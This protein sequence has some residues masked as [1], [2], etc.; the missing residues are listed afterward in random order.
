MGNLPPKRAENIVDAE[1]KK[2]LIIGLPGIGKTL[3]CE[4]MLRDWASERLFTESQDSE[5][6]IRIAFLIKFRRLNTVGELSLRELLEKA[7]FLPTKHLPDDVWNDIIKNPDKVLILF[8]GADEYKNHSSIA[9]KTVDSGIYSV[10]DRM[11]LHA[12]YSKVAEGKLLDKAAVL[13]TI[14]PTAV[15][16]VKHITFRTYE[17]LGFSPQQVEEYVEKFT[18]DAAGNLSDAGEKIKEHIK[19]NAKISA[20]CYIPA[21]CF[22][23]C[24]SLLHVLKTSAETGKDLTAVG[25]GKLTQIYNVA[26]KVFFFKRSEQHRDKR[27]SQSDIFSN[28][29]IG[30]E[31]FKQLGEIAFKGLENGRIIFEESEVEKV[32][33]SSLLYQMP[34]SC[35]PWKP[36]IHQ[37]CFIHLTLQ[38]YF[39]ARHITETMNEAQLRTFVKDHINKGKWHVVLNFVSGLLGERDEQ[40]MKIFTDLL[41]EETEEKD[42]DELMFMPLESEPRTFTCWP[43]RSEK[44]LA[45]TILKCVHEGSESNVVQRKLESI[46]FNAV[47]FSYCSLAPADCTAIA[48]V[49]KHVQQIS[50]IN[51]YHNNIGS[52]GCAEIAKLFDNDNSQLTHLNLR[53]NDIG[54]EGVKQLSK[55]IGNSNLESLDL[56]LN[57]ITDKGLNDLSDKLVN[58]NVK[59]LDLSDNNITDKGLNYLSD[60]LVNT[61]VKSLDLSHNSITDK[62]LNYLSDKLVNT[63]LKSLNLSGNN[64]TDKGLNYLSDKLVNTNLNRTSVAIFTDKGLNY[65]SDKLVNT[66]LDVK[67]LDKTMLGYEAGTR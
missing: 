8:D 13:T 44:H 16:S 53:R 19:K 22:I 30:K 25:L 26:A 60:K 49:F 14:R 42:E 21:S 63:N 10:D 17:I 23:I 34:D 58:T 62:G 35:E 36:P 65:L 18:K 31:E 57:S 55:V 67:D 54:D 5:L 51:L 15:S 28:E 20:F 9:N 48:H 2:I 52:L 56:S 50:L 45:L 37:F 7:E 47:D 61:K 11:P 32:K 39:A 3:F 66:N 40:L 6:H 38:E 24:S 27:L 41:P 12:L 46:R 4:R 59:S 64:F 43:T 1:N 33:N 29:F